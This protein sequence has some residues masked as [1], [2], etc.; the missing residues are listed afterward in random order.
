[1]KSQVKDL[2]EDYEFY[3]FEQ[4]IPDWEIYQPEKSH[5]KWRAKRKEDEKIVGGSKIQTVI[6][7]A[8]LQ[9]IGYGPPT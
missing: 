6:V 8:L 7:K 3:A 1:M 2:I 9:D 5:D 4:L